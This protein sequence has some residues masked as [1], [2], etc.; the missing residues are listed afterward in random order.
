MRQLSMKADNIVII[1]QS[2]QTCSTLGQSFGG[3]SISGACRTLI[4][5][6]P[7]PS[8]K[9]IS[10][11]VKHSPHRDRQFTIVTSNHPDIARCRALRNRQFTSLLRVNLRAN[12][13]RRVQ[14]RVSTLGRPYY[15][16][17]ACNTSP[18]LSRQLNLDER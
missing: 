1:T 4:R 15:K 11:P 7:S 5:N 2:R 13:A 9:A 6:R 10:T 12:Q 16:S 18:I 8:S 17:L 14:I 3:H